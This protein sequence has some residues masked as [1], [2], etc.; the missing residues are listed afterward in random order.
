MYD[1]IRLASQK[2]SARKE[3]RR[4]IVVLSDGADNTSGISASKALKAAQKAN[5]TIYTVDMSSIDTGG[6]KKVQN[7]RILKKFANKT[8]GRFVK[9]PG[10]FALRDA[11]KNI[12]M[13]LSVT[14]TIGYYPKNLREDGKWQELELISKDGHKIRSREGFY[15]N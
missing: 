11:F 13:E 1:S 6:G 3:K 8:G 2:L 7:R 10:G 14:N 9:A 12:V 15:A 4:A 5:A